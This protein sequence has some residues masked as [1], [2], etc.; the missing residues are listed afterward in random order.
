MAWNRGR[1][2]ALPATAACVTDI[3][4]LAEKLC[5]QEWIDSLGLVSLEAVWREIELPE[6]PR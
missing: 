5:L 6:P 1:P 4:T 2:A 3:T